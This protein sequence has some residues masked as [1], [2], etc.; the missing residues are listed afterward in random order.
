MANP[1]TLEQAQEH[2]TA[3]LA[4][5]RAV[6][7]GQEYEIDTG[8]SRRKLKRTDSKT[9]RDNIAYWSGMV[10]QL[11]SG[12]RAPKMKLVVNRD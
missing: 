5:D 12:S 3:W 2:L 6:A 11:M 1:I 10:S 7:S 4:A 9:I 8:G